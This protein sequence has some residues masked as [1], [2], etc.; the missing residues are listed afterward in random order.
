MTEELSS[1][2]LREKV[3]FLALNCPKGKR[4]EACP[5]SW[6]PEAINEKKQALAT[7]TDDMLLQVLKN[8]IQCLQITVENVT[9][10]TSFGWKPIISHGSRDSA[11]MTFVKK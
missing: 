8:H 4:S 11:T 6:L 1:S 9:E 7:L 2:A 5:L 10:H 3:W